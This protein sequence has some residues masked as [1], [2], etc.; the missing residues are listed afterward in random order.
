MARLRL[1]K[2]P[3]LR[4]RTKPCGRMCSKKRHKNSS[5][6]RDSNFCSLWCSGITP[7]KS[8][9]AI[10]EGDQA[11]VGDG[12]AMGVAAQILQHIFGATEGTFQVDHPVLSVAVAAA[13]Q[14]R[15]WVAQEASG[16]RGS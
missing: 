3:K 11:M 4:M 6:D 1:A 8:D 13:R 14:R 5:S 9:L 15:S 7:A 16:L 2:K 10:G 12:H